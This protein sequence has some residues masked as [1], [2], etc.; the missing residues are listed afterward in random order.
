MSADTQPPSGTPNEP[1]RN[2]PQPAQPQAG[3]AQPGSGHVSEQ[4]TRPIPPPPPYQ[5]GTQ[6]PPAVHPHQAPSSDPFAF[7]T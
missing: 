1:Q 4:H 6:Q 2:A 7:M 5:H 3:E